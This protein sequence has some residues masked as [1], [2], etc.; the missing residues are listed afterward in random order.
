[1]P[2]SIGYLIGAFTGSAAVFFLVW[3]LLLAGG[4][5]APWIPAGL[6]AAVVLLV[7][8]SAR[9]VVMRRAWTRYLLE[10]GVPQQTSRAKRSKAGASRNTYS[11]SLHSAALAAI[12]KRSSAVD[13]SSSAE[14]HFEIFKLCQNYLDSAAEALRSNSLSTE[15]RHALKSGQ[16]RA[17]A[18]ERHH[19]LTWA[20]D[21]SRSLTH[22]AQRRARMYDKIE[23]AHRAIDC[24]DFALKIFPDEQG[25]NES[26][27]A[28]KEF[29]ASV[30]V[31]HWVEL[32]ERAAFKGHYRRAINRYKDA[33]FYLDRES[34]KEDVRRTGSEKIE[35]EIELL[36]A[37]LKSPAQSAEPGT[38]S[39]KPKE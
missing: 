33:L 25:L 38:F 28:I 24:L 39:G 19:L 21:S 12:Q 22:E 27:L 18:L 31:A 8:L 29:I 37:R 13:S 16:E 32:A 10:H 9:E 7:T 17:R 1:M 23:T 5:Q 4:D 15:K 30:K 11:T 6:A 2:S 36:Q 34:V 35:L 14:A 3:G 20:R 26:K